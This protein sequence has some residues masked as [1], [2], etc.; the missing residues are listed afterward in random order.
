MNQAQVTSGPIPDLLL[1]YLRRRDISQRELAREVGR[2]P[3]AIR[4]LMTG[5]S[6]GVKPWG[7]DSLL[8]M[9]ARALEI[10][11]RELDRAVIA[12][13]RGLSEASLASAADTKRRAP[14]KRRA[15]TG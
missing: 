12:H 8:F 9:V 5:E 10:P 4:T 1:R 14:S 6:A 7:G 13:Y 15:H 3:K 2:D 11:Q